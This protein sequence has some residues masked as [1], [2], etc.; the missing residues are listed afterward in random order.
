MTIDEKLAETNSRI[1][2]SGGILFFDMQK[3]MWMITVVNAAPKPAYQY[4]NGKW[5][6][7]L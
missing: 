5:E 2:R 6:R 4:S 7:K 1:R 3:L